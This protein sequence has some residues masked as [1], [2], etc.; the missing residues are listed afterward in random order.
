LLSAGELKVADLPG[1]GDRDRIALAR[2]LIV[3]GIATVPGAGNG[4]GD[5]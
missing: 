5:A 3:D 1:P 4:V 2:R